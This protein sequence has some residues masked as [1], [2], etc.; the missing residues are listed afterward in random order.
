MECLFVFLIR[1]DKHALTFH[2]LL[3]YALP[4]I[5]ERK[6]KTKLLQTTVRTTVQRS[7]ASR[8][9]KIIEYVLKQLS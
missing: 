2:A 8:A 1:L 6:F 3:A 7:I 9:I 5:P 4:G